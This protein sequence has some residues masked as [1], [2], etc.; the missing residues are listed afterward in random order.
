[1]LTKIKTIKIKEI[2]NSQGSIK[3]ILNKKDF[4][5][6]GF[7]EFYINEIKRNVTKGWN[8]HKKNS[9]IIYMISGKIC[10]TFS[11]D[12]K[13]MKKITLSDK[14]KK[15]LIIP[16]QIWFKFKSKEPNSSFIN[17]IERVHSDNEIKKK[18]LNDINNNTHL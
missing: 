11:R 14:S 9:C 16:P 13:K 3:K 2:K 10:F 8:L 1:M 18:L 12:F 5:Y 7:G 4:F 17:I 6:K 15:L